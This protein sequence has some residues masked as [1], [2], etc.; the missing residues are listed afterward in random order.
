MLEKIPCLELR[1][2]QMVIMDNAS[3]HK[4]HRIRDIIEN[5]G[6]QL[7][8][9]PLYLPDLNPIDHYWAWLKNKL[10]YLWRHITDFYDR[11]SFALNRN[12]EPMLISFTIDG[13][14]DKKR[15]FFLN[16]LLLSCAQELKR[17]AEKQEGK[18]NKDTFL[19][20]CKQFSDLTAFC[21]AHE[22]AC[23]KEEFN[24]IYESIDK[25]VCLKSIEQLTFAFFAARS[26]KER[27]KHL[28]N[29]GIFVSFF[30]D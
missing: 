2:K 22:I 27:E 26:P 7:L 24:Q 8:D 9:L 4:F 17:E 28:S 23:T 21:S 3:F 10:S 11:L 30:E 18:V 14:I 15:D 6:C 5:V 13:D 20:S 29:I 19:G 16:K 1:P 25:T 12:S